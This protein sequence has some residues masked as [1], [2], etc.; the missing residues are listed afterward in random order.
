MSKLVEK[1]ASLGTEAN[2]YLRTKKSSTQYVYRSGLRL[3]LEFYQ[4]KYGEEINL[5][6]FLDRLDVNAQLPR[7]EKKR[8]AES[9]LN[10]FIDF[11]AD[12]GK[13]NN[14][15]RTYFASVQNFLK[16]KGFEL[17][18]RFVRLPPPTIKEVNH[19]HA[20]KIEEIRE[21]VDSANSMRDKAIILCLFQSGLAINELCDLNYGNI[22]AELEAEKLPLYLSLTRQKTGQEFK[23]FFGRDAIK[24]LM[25]YLETR[26]NLKRNSPLFTMS[27]SNVNR[28]TVGAI[29]SKFREFAQDLSFIKKHELEGFNPVRPHSLR[30]AFRSRLTNK[31]DSDLIEF[32]MGHAIGGVKRAYMNLPIDELRELYSNFEHLLAIEKT[33]KDELIER[34]EVKIPPGIK[35]EI[36]ELKTT[37]STLS[38][39]NVELENDLNAFKRR[40]DHFSNT[41]DLSQEEANALSEIIKDYINKE[42]IEADHEARR[43]DKEWKNSK[44]AKEVVRN[45]LQQNP[46]ELYEEIKKR[47]KEIP[48]DEV[49]DEERQQ[50]ERERRINET[51]CKA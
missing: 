44:E 50:K 29:Q 28:L 47:N 16:Y 4:K 25:L 15:I 46:R 35:K 2:E 49:W 6:N 39:R 5:S 36:E 43:K 48:E 21:F 38:K 19:K 1:T 26:K 27:G 11:L 14:S 24:Y 17:S 23:T 22:I 41:M 13:S 18:G 12:N 45:M 37:V 31:V 51:N 34:K 10:S 3:F 8:L 40:F 7:R 20:W 9:E 33:S 32:F 42:R 30:S